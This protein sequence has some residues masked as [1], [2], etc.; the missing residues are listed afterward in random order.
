M[1]SALFRLLRTVTLVPLAMRA[2]ITPKAPKKIVGSI[3]KTVYD[4]TV[5]VT[6]VVRVGDD[7]PVPLSVIM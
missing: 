3:P 2:N 1:A 5:N 6:V 7:P 4:L